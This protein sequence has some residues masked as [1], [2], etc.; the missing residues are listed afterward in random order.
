MHASVAFMSKLASVSL[1][2][3]GFVDVSS[4]RSWLGNEELVAAYILCNM[5]LVA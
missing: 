4:T 5:I 1:T 3:E 2:S